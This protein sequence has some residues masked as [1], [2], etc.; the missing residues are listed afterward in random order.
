VDSTERLEKRFEEW[1]PKEYLA[2]YEGDA[3]V[4]QSSYKLLGVL[5][6]YT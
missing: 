3:I 5:E 6:R 1:N 2:I 4:C